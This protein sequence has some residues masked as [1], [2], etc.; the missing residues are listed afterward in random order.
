[1]G[2]RCC[3]LGCWFASDDFYRADSTDIGPKWDEVNG[4][5]EITSFMLKENGNAGAIA[6]FLPT[7][8]TVSMIA[9]VTTVDE[10]AGNKYRLIVNYKD[11]TSYMYAELTIGPGPLNDSTL[12]LYKVNGG[13]TTELE[14]ETIQGL[15][16]G[17]NG[18]SREIYACIGSNGFVAT[19]T[20]AVVSMVWHE[21][22]PATTGVYG[23]LGNGADQEIYFDDFSLQE[24]IDTDPTC[25]GCICT[26]D[27]KTWPK[28]LLLEIEGEG[29]CVVSTS[30][31]LTYDR[32]N[33]AWRGSAT[34]CGD[35]WGFSLACA[36]ELENIVLVF[37][38][39][40]GCNNDASI[41]VVLQEELSSCNPI[42]F[43]F[44]QDVPGT[45]LSCGCCPPKIPP[46]SGV[47]WYTITVPI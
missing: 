15:A 1:M 5:W 32:I 40:H 16:E 25:P 35:T 38:T 39:L 47:I 28:E 8:N 44:K 36:L 18:R 14:L 9:R 22:P 46:V 4:D 45:W 37:T 41:P 17:P 19:V 11:E 43:I 12:G 2:R 3:C 23:G 7:P 24:H 21:D 6:Q 26:C 30:L 31:T 34:V 27:G 20:N 33:A 10:V 29:N 13:T 42:E